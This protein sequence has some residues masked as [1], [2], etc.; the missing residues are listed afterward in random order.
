MPDKLIFIRHSAVQIDPARPSR[1]WLLSVDGRTRCRQLAPALDNYQPTRILTSR[2]AKA[3]E[4]GR[5]LAEELGL[6]WQTAPNLHEHDRVGAPYFDSQEAF[7]A[8]IAQLFRQPDELLF[9][10]ETANEA[11]HRFDTAVRQLLHK[12]PD[13]TLA[14]AT[15]GTILTLFLAHYNSQLNPFT[16]W[17]NLPLPCAVIVSLPTL[18]LLEKLFTI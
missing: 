5:I 18:T 12:F 15:H 13:D 6:P 2:E 3:A 7:H 8:I 17:Q 9:G 11:L 4:T 16:Y 10:N 1:E 14:I